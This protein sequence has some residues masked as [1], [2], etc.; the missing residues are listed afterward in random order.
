MQFFKQLSL[1][2]LSLAVSYI[3]ISTIQCLDNRIQ[4][5]TGYPHLTHFSPL[6]HSQVTHFSLSKVTNHLSK[7]INPVLNEL[8]GISKGYNVAR[9]KKSFGFSWN[10]KCTNS[11][12]IIDTT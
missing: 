3:K 11:F 9:L 12:K 4:I 10:T 6:F 2:K 1:S 8:E 7:Q 5:L